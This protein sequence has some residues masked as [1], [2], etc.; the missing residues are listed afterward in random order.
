MND[1]N[2]IKLPEMEG[3]D[4]EQAL[5]LERAALEINRSK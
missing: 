2:I 3:I 4:D 5:Y 1:T